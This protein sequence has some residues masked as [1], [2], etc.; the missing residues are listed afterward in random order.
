VV[1]A[2]NINGEARI[3]VLERDAG[4]AV[5]EVADDLV[6]P[7][8]YE[9][10]GFHEAAAHD[11]GL[12]GGEEDAFTVDGVDVV[13]DEGD[14][15]RGGRGTYAHEVAVARAPAVVGG[16]EE[17]AG[18]VAFVGGGFGLCAS[19]KLVAELAGRFED[20]DADFRANAGAVPKCTGD[21]ALGKLE[22]F[23]DQCL[24]RRLHTHG[25][26]SSMRICQILFVSH[27]FMRMLGQK[28]VFQERQDSEDK[29]PA[30]GKT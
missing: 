17:D 29:E 26:Y 15:K 10:E 21:R 16:M 4:E 13:E 6:R 2:H 3:L 14:V 30:A 19:G 7:A 22:R 9:D 23:S 27:I 12:I 25:L 1:D 18:E 11:G 5:G 28:N 20:A 24:D 8:E